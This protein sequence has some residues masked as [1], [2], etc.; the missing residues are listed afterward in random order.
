MSPPISREVIELVQSLFEERSLL[1][2]VRG[3]DRR[4]AILNR[5][6]ATRDI[7]VVPNLLPLMTTDDA[8]APQVARTIAEVVRDV[9]PVQLSWLDEQVRHSSYA[10]S[11]SDAWYQLAPSAVPR[12]AQGAEFDGAVIGLIASHS[13]GF[14]RAAALEV[15]AEHTGGQEIPFLALRANDWV[16]AVA[17]RGTELLISRLRSDNR[18][19]VVNALPFIVRVLRQHRRD[20]DG[21]ERALKLVLLSDGGDDALARSSQFDTS[22]RRK[23]YALLIA[24]TTASKRRLFDAALKDPDAVVRARAILSVAK[25][26][27]FG[28]RAEILERFLRADRVPGVRRLAL[29]LLSEHT[30][31]RIAKVFPEV[32]LDRAA[33]VRG[34]ARFVA[35]THQPALIPRAIYAEAL[36]ASLPGQLAAAIDGVGETGTRV[37]AD[38]IVPF[39]SGNR[40]SF[41]RAALWALARLDAE[42]AISAAITALSDDSSSVRSGAAAILA[43]NANKVDFD[44]VSRR[45]RSLSDPIARGR[46][47]RIFLEASKWEAPVFLLETLKDPDDG[48]R[49]LAIRLIDRW[50]AGFNRNQT[51]PT[52]RQLQRIAA[53]LDSVASRMPEE[54]A[55]MLR[56]STKPV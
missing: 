18:H 6:A 23:M 27:D 33:S 17:A 1:E 4:L 39:L 25:N 24:G 26:P 3:H 38:L 50:I 13:N 29:S 28:D 34:L 20:H 32:L 43:M 55:K 22:V 48:V 12:L 41:R 42:R 54:T 46:L 8:L 21:I 14:V 9:T 49:T 19:A 47:L 44:I 30:P 5:I 56:F 52:A 31:A 15:L 2:R 45:V 10:H 35:G 51:Q 53:L 40:P 7:R 11:W 16:D 37:D 36:V